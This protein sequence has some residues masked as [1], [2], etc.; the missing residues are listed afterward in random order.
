MVSKGRVIAA[1][2]RAVAFKGRAVEFRPNA[3]RARAKGILLGDCAVAREANEL[4]ADMSGTTAEAR[5]R[6]LGF[7]AIDSTGIALVSEAATPVLKTIAR[8]S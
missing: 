2:G 8:A 7:I 6:Q 4:V 1:K 5:A 3:V